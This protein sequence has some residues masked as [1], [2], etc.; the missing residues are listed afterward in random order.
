MNPD[1]VN[2]DRVDADLVDASRVDASRV[3]ADRVDADRVRAELDRIVD[4]CSAVA[5]APA[6]IVA[7]GLIRE[8]SLTDG[9]DG[10]AV[11][12]RIGVTEPGCLMGGSFAAQARER[13]DRLNGVA[14]VEV[15]FDHAAD[16]TPGDMEPGYRRTLDATRAARRAALRE[17]FGVR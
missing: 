13:L 8:L 15:E 9:P 17:R 2:P 12:I 1:R 6:G 3:D 10:V 5:G 11:R 14:S 4:P 7:M 16:W